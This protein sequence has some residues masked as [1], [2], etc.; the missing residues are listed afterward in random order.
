MYQPGRACSACP[1]T[2]SC[3]SAYPG[4]CSSTSLNI[5]SNSVNSNQQ[6]SKAFTTSDSAS[7]K[8]SDSSI[9]KRIRNDES[10]SSSLII[11]PN[12]SL[13]IR[14]EPRVVETSF[15]SRQGSLATNNRVRPR[16]RYYNNNNA[17]RR[18]RPCRNILCSFLRLFE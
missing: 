5:F 6:P 4:L 18:T 16:T 14:R 11:R 7:R 10:Q 8:I 17:I 1:G 2:S 15:A 9:S 13:V 3:T 12:S